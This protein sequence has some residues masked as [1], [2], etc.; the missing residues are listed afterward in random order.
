MIQ[1]HECEQGSEAWLKARLGIPTASSFSTVMAKGEGKTRSA[2]MRK[3]AG[4]ILTGE[5][6]SSFS[7]GHMERG[8]EMEAEARGYYAMLK[9]AD[10]RLVGFVSNGPKGCSPDAL[11]STDGGLEIK[12]AEPHILIELLLRD[13]F[14]PEH[15]AQV[16]GNIWITE[17]DWFD[18]IVYWPKMPSLIKRARRDEAYI[19]TMSGEVDRFNDELQTLVAKLRRY[20][21]GPAEIAA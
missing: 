12:T 13:D 19:A 3:L 4:E 8:K 10:P 20:G 11:L 16:Q 15:R 18:I 14:P 7:N 21:V 5:P 2:Y 1:V 9:D 6:A 17:R